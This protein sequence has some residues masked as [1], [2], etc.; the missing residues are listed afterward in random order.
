MEHDG[1]FACRY[2]NTTKPASEFYAQ[3]KVKCKQCVN[4]SNRE[5]HHRLYA[6]RNIA[7]R[8]A[9]EREA[10]AVRITHTVAERAYLAGIVDGEGSIQVRLRGVKGGTALRPGQF[11]LVVQVVNTSK[12]LI[13][14]LVATWGG[15]V[16]F[17]PENREENRKGKYTWTIAAN[18]A[19][20]LLDEIMEFMVI[21]RRQCVLGRRFQR[22]A[23]GAGRP[24]TEKIERL[25]LRFYSEMKK[26]NHRGVAPLN[27]E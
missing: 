15:A 3:S 27:T 1:Q 4:A 24:R 12:P 13:D 8:R 14:W 6:A 2:C 23:Q 10:K 9:K 21:K 22:W 16:G 20:A 18:N 25:H 17:S 7:A 26:L 19:L 11:T 5:R